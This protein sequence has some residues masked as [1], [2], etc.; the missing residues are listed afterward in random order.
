MITPS[1]ISLKRR[2]LALLSS[3]FFS[4]ASFVTFAQ[5]TYADDTNTLKIR[6]VGNFDDP[7]PSSGAALKTAGAV[8]AS[9]LEI[10]TLVAGSLAV[11]YLIYGGIK[12]IS[13]AGAPDKVKSARTTIIHAIIGIIIISCAYLIIA[14]A[15]NLGTFATT[16]G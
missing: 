14:I 9:A 15:K 8:Y 2:G 1:N 3:G 12:Y 16:I 10:I 13:S 6:P 4:I 11:I 7:A 5:R